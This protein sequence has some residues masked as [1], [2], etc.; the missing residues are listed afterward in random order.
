MSIEHRTTPAQV[1]R[2]RSLSAAA[3]YV[4]EQFPPAQAV[5]LAFSCVVEYL[6][7][8][9]AAGELSIEGSAVLA[10]V[11]VALLFLQLRLV[12]DIHT[13][14]DSG[15]TGDIGGATVRGLVAGMVVTTA[16]IVLLNL[17]DGSM[18]IASLAIVAFLV[19][20][21]LVIQAKTLLPGWVRMVLG[22]IPLFELAP[23]MMLAYV[24]LGWRSG[25][26]GTLEVADVAVVVGLFL[27]SFNVW[28]LSR[29]MGERARERIYQLTWP[30]VRVLCL[31]LLVASAGLSVALYS[32]ADLSAL[33][34][35]YALVLCALFAAMSRPRREPDSARPWWVGLPFP[36]AMTAGLFVQL[37]ALT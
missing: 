31:G 18:L 34:L 30:V 2:S 37:L 20:T 36:T 16:V 17:V 8:G 21:S 33:W 1:G 22:R 26:G 35:A 24:Y 5:A 7:F 23:A 3:G 14:Y 12:D 29:H 10:A 4:M 9:R 15:G 6:A 13:F 11:T 32:R 19:A 28:K 27:A 25:T